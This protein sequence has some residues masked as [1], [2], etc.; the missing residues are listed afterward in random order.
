MALRI[1]IEERRPKMNEELRLINEDLRRRCTFM[2]NMPLAFLSLFFLVGLLSACDRRELTYPD[3]VQITITADWSKAGLSEQENQYGATAIFY[4]A[5]GGEPI[6]VLMGDRNYQNVH[7]K[8]GRYNVI[9]F[10]RSFEDFGTIAFRGMDA[11]HKLEAHVKNAQTKGTDSNKVT[12]DSPDGLAADCV[13]GFE[14]ADKGCHLDF[15]PQKMTKEITASIHI[16]GMNNIRTATCTLSGVSE[17][18]F[19]ASG[20]VSEQLMT[21]QFELGNPAYLAGSKT[22]GKMSATFSVFGFDEN[23]TH[24]VHFKALL[25]DGKTKF[26]EELKDMKVDVKE[27]SEGIVHI[28]IEVVC[29]ETVPT[30]RPEGS[31]GM[32]ADVDDWT[33]EEN[34]DINI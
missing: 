1:Q 3:G 4:P 10:N 30:V 12:T 34:T 14:V 20:K 31:S 7:I 11:R 27:V 29:G 25:V 13:E 17:S 22:E 23:I 8:K 15:I 26:E 16:K 2:L 21:Q 32:D 6:T 5:D 18:V 28:T 33:K 19:L 9:L 24:D